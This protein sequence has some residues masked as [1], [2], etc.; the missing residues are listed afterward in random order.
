MTSLGTELAD[1]LIGLAY[2]KGLE[3]TWLII[4]VSHFDSSNGRL[5]LEHSKIIV[6]GIAPAF[7]CYDS[8]F[9]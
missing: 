1:S 5:K 2:K 3:A 9:V 7:M 4:S 8:Y 6:L